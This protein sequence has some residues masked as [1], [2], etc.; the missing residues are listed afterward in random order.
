MSFFMRGELTILKRIILYVM[1]LYARE[2]YCIPRDNT[3]L[4][5]FIKTASR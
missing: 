5:F 2:V 4:L 3:V 1:R